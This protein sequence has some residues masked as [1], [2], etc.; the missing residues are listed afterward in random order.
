MLAYVALTESF[1][2]SLLA[3]AISEG[4]ATGAVSL[5]GALSA[6]VAAELAVEAKVDAGS[7]AFTTC[8]PSC[9]SSTRQPRIAFPTASDWTLCRTLVT[10]TD[11]LGGLPCHLPLETVVIPFFS[12]PFLVRVRVQGAWPGRAQQIDG[13]GEAVPHARHWSHSVQERLCSGEKHTLCVRH[14]PSPSIIFSFVTSL[15]VPGGSGGLVGGSRGVPRGSRE[16]AGEGSAPGRGVPSHSGG[17]PG[18]WY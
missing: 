8:K 10:G 5:G 17:P 14:H 3:G 9:Q 15:G 16:G 11:L 7:A 12:S 4:V 13:I 1:P 18:V 2:D 6:G